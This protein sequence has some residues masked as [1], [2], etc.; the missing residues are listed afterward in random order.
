MIEFCYFIKVNSLRKNIEWKYMATLSLEYGKRPRCLMIYSFL[1]ILNN[2]ILQ[3]AN[4]R[5]IHLYNFAARS[6]FTLRIFLFVCDA[7]QVTF[8]KKIVFR[9]IFFQLNINNSCQ[10]I[11]R[12][13]FAFLYFSFNFVPYPALNSSQF[14]QF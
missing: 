4:N 8:I 9:C 1:P 11:T 14:L 3:N 7:T 6:A 13:C 10:R 2:A 5:I 12:A